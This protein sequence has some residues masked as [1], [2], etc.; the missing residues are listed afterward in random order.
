MEQHSPTLSPTIRRYGRLVGA[1]S[2]LLVLGCQPVPKT[3]PSAAHAGLIGKT[4]QEL[5]TCADA[6]LSKTPRG[7]ET[8]LVYH[9]NA[10]AFDRS[11]FGSKASVDSV[12]HG[13]TALLTLKDDRVVA[14][15]YRPEPASI[16][17]EDH[18]EEI[19]QNCVP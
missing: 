14:V 3:D 6:P 15:E 18:C 11:F 12:H 10:P 13:C 2:L 16:A 7:Q 19:F 5:L 8:V 17:A 9:R 4:K 1:A